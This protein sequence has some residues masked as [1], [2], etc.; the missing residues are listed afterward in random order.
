MPWK[1]LPKRSVSALHHLLI[2][3]DMFFFGEEQ[4]PHGAHVVAGHGDAGG[5]RAFAQ[6][7]YQLVG[8][9]YQRIEKAGLRGLD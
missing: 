7:F 4:A 8:V 9:S 6:T 3:D 2:I 5:C 1:N